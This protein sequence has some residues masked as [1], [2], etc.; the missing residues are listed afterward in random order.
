[1][2]LNFEL[3]EKLKNE[4]MASNLGDDAKK[5]LVAIVTEKVFDETREKGRIEDDLAYYHKK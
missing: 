4:I 5:L 3:L 1:M 2:E